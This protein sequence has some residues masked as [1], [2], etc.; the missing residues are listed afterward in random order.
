METFRVI[1]MFSV[2]F[3]FIIRQPQGFSFSP[4]T[5]CSFFPSALYS[6]LHPPSHPGG[7]NSV[8]NWTIFLPNLFPVL[9]FCFTP[10]V[11]QFE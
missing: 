9:L 6:Y 2:A 1:L 10:I 11:S 5:N 4:L 7:L 3:D 8:I